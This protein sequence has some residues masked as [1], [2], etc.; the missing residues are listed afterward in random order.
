VFDTECKQTLY[1]WID[2][3]TPAEQTWPL[4]NR[5]LQVLRDGN[6]LTYFDGKRIHHRAVTVI[7]T[8][9]ATVEVLMPDRKAYRD[10]FI[11]APLDLL[12]TPKEPKDAEGKPVYDKYRSIFA[13]CSFRH[14]VGMMLKGDLTAK[15]K[16]IVRMRIKNANDRGIEARYWETPGWPVRWRNA[17]WR[18]LIDEGV[19]L[20]N[21]DDPK[22]A[23]FGDW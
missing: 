8:G 3:K 20:L 2:F 10:Y 11:D 1:L 23:A 19:G 16:E 13:S 9:A 22:E 4:L 17:V 15:Q 14:D 7:A 12:N 5:D 6:H 18:F 21:T